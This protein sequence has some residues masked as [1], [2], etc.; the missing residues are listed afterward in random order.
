MNIRTLPA[1]P[2]QAD[3]LTDIAVAAKRYWNYPERWIQ[4]WLPQLTVSTD[5]IS[6]NET[7]VAQ[8]DDSIAGW[9]SLTDSD[10]GLWLDNLWV[11]PGFIGEGIGRS[12]FQHSLERCRLRKASLLKILSD[13]NAESFYRHMGARK[14]NEQHGEVD[15]TPRILPVMEI[16]L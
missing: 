14:V 1:S 3:A 7:W 6:A 10:E 5:Y 2:E 12:L 8:T 9:Y 16:G 15:G 11:L 13:P 4:I